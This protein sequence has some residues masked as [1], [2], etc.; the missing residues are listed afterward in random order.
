MT[1]INLIHI[2]NLKDKISNIKHDIVNSAVEQR[3]A[4]VSKDNFNFELD[5]KHKD[6]IYSIFV[7][8]S[9]KI[10]NKF[11]LS[12]DNFKLWCYFT[13]EKYTQGNGVWHNHTNTATIN[14]VL[15]LITEKN[16]GIE[17][18]DIYIEPNDFDLLIFPGYLSHS[19][20]ISNSNR[21]ISLNIELRCIESA[22][23]IFKNEKETSSN[24]HHSEASD[25]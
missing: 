5:S 7:E 9:K 8:E 19:P 25:E 6:Y 10:L 13:D 3:D 12:D 4:K 21:R 11:T 2:I 24:S 18:E 20:I 1:S 17:F 14:G 15:Y 23:K 16:S 22:S